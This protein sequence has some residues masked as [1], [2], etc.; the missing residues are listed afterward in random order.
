MMLEES[1]ERTKTTY[2]EGQTE[3]CSTGIDS[4]AVGQHR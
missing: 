4:P 2:R 3:F 1:Y